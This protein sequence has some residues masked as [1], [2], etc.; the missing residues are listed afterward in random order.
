MKSLRG[1]C[2]PVGLGQREGDGDRNSGIHWPAI[3]AKAGMYVLCAMLKY[4]G[5][6]TAYTWRSSLPAACKFPQTGALGVWVSTQHVCPRS[7][8]AR[9]IFFPVCLTDWNAQRLEMFS[10]MFP[11]SSEVLG[12]TGA[13][14]PGAEGISLVIKCSSFPS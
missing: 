7:H 14:L 6:R 4:T 12:T 13:A 10:S 3:L 11:A 9:P 2:V 8:L 5:Q 1:C